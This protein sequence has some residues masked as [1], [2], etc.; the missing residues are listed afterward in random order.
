M[1]LSRATHPGGD[2]AHQTKARPFENGTVITRVLRVLAIRFPDRV[3]RRQCRQNG[4]MHP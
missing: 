2:H 1:G 3:Q 4:R